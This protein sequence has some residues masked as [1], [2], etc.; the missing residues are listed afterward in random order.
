MSLPKSKLQ[1]EFAGYTTGDHR[2]L[3]ATLESAMDG[4]RPLLA[5]NLSSRALSRQCDMEIR[6]AFST[7]AYAIGKLLDVL[8]Y[9]EGQPTIAIILTDVLNKRDL[10]LC[11]EQFRSLPSELH[12]ADF[13]PCEGV[14]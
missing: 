11:E 5:A 10:K 8:D 7:A 14:V 3:A 1:T 13:A 2:M 12:M 4:H 6:M 9:S